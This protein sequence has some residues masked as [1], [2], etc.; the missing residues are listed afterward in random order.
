MTRILRN[1]LQTYHSTAQ[2]EVVLIHIE[3]ASV[4]QNLGT[5]LEGE[6]QL[7]LLKQTSTRVPAGHS[8]K[9]TYRNFHTIR[10]TFI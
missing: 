1:N 6:Q 2:E 4:F 3:F 10:R 9:T 7:V 8:N 5:H